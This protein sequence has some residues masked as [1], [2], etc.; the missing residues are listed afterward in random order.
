MKNI[1]ANREEAAKVLATKLLQYQNCNGLILA[2]PRGG[3]VIGY[4][5]AKE[6]NLPLDIL[7]VKK[8]GAPGNPEYAIG[9]VFQDGTTIIN[10]GASRHKLPENY[11]EEEKQKQL[12]KIKEVRKLYGVAG[13]KI[14]INN[15]I[16]FLVD[17]GVA[18]GSTILVAAQ[19]LQQKNPEKII[20]AVPVVPLDT[21]YNLQKKVDE[22]VCVLTPESF[23]AVGQFYEDF[24]QV[25]DEEVEKYLTEI[26]NDE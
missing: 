8:I 22:V 11:F 15:K 21:L 9:A 19:A 5:L 18:T 7:C 17:D 14:D 4:H 16:I 6:L 20:I 24:N 3:V 25:T 23:F 1:F 13:K 12:D 10:P 26:T 2:I